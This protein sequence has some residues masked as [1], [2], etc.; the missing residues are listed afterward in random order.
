[1]DNGENGVLVER[2]L[3][4]LH[5]ALLTT[6]KEL[7]G[8]SKTSPILDLGCGTGAWLKRMHDA[9][10][11]ELWGVD[12]D[13]KGFAAKEVVRFIPADLGGNEKVIEATRTDFK[14]ATIIEVIEHVANPQKL[15]ECA[16][17]ALAPGG[18]MLITSPNVYSLRA[19]AR[20]FAFGGMP[21]FERRAHS[22]PVEADHIHPILLEAYERKIFTPLGLILTRLWT[23][24][25][26][27]S[28]GSRLSAR[29]AA[30]LMR[31]ALADQLPGDTLCLLLRKPPGNPVA[32][33]PY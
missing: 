8:L 26:H 28:V 10:Y 16:F 5:A 31:I 27:G 2:T 33:A 13:A 11:R 19:R 23:H 3:P 22:V 30:R 14:L 21:F 24:P 32:A 9:G 7:E 4:G 1:M 29:I 18:W 6:V 12:R 17:R 20:F 15:V 25:E